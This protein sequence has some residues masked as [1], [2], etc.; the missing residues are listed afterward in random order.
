MFNRGMR[1]DPAAQQTRSAMEEDGEEEYGENENSESDL[2][3]D[4]DATCWRLLAEW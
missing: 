1:I 3:D 2:S 4:D